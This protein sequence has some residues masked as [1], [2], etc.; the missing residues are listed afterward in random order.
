MAPLERMTL[1]SEYKLIKPSIMIDLKKNR[2]RIHQNTLY[3]IG[4]P[5]YVLLLV[6][7]DE[8]TLAI[9]KSTRSDPKAHPITK[10]S[11]TNKKSFELYS[12]SL[13]KSLREICIHWQDNQLYRLYGKIIF[14]EGIA[15]F[16]MDDSILISGAKS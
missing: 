1:M 8:C 15:Q 11:H 3:A 7:P 2:I 4:N 13:T 5:D 10:K 12:R 9:L 6:N 16:H 14:N